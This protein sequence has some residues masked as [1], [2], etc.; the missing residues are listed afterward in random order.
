MERGFVSR[1]CSARRKLLAL[2]L[3]AALVLFLNRRALVRAARRLL[4]AT[5]SGISASEQ[6]TRAL[7]AAASDLRAYLAPPLASAHSTGA[8]PHFVGVPSSAARRPAAFGGSSPLVS[9]R[10]S[11]GLML[12]AASMVAPVGAESFG[13][14]GGGGGGGGVESEQV[15]RS[16]RRALRVLA[17]PECACVLRNL[18]AGAAQG[19]VREATR[20][21]DDEERELRSLSAAVPRAA[22][23]SRRRAA[24]ADGSTSRAGGSIGGRSPLAQLFAALQT[25]GG[26]K[27]AVALV[28]SA[29]HEAVSVALESAALHARRGGGNGGSNGGSGGGSG[30]TVHTAT[31]AAPSDG[32]LGV[33]FESAMRA[34][35]NNESGLR[36]VREVVRSAVDAAAPLVLA[37][38]AQ[39]AQ[40]RG[41][42]GT[43]ENAS[44]TQWVK[45]NPVLLRDLA[46][47][48]TR[49][50]VCAYLNLGG[51]SAKAEVIVD[52][53]KKDGEDSKSRW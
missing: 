43:H 30:G 5:S 7:A 51:R 20:E 38:A 52:V 41:S 25:P 18:T 35:G 10:S 17:T 15:P 12:P 16:V 13:G 36:V 2:A 6:L 40:A 44:L 53:E 32:G 23:A 47:V 45:R 42:S 21:Q 19:A 34:V 48:I 22:A 39:A 27:L 1:V 31:N 9:R 37:Q 3:A 4:R 8:M 46:A 28:R 33:H 49:E 26:E 14:G 50:A 11:A 29:V 24:A